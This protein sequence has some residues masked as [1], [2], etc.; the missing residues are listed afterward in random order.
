MHRSTR[1]Q[2][3]PF[4][5]HAVA[6]AIA[7]ALG[8]PGQAKA[9]GEPVLAT[10]QYYSYGGSVSSDPINAF[11]INTGQALL[12]LGS[13]RLFVGGNAA[14]S[15]SALA[16]AQMSVGQLVAGFGGSGT[17]SIDVSGAG[18]L[19]QVGGSGRLDIGSWGTGRWPMATGHR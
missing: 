17:G 14:G 3:R 16:G 2:H 11:P 10:V 13:N 4:N 15:F 5:R 9:L 19:V 12:N 6:I 7:L 18:A 8:G 1:Q